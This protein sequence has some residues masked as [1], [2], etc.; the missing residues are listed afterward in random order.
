MSQLFFLLNITSFIKLKLNEL[1]EN[2]ILQK[3]FKIFIKIVNLLD[4]IE[5]YSCY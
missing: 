5:N 1:Y 3:R 2:F 4:L